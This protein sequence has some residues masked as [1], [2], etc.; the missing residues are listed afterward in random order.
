MFLHL[1]RRPHDH[2]DEFA[3]ADLGDRRRPS[4]APG[5]M[6]ARTGPAAV[7]CPGRRGLHRADLLVPVQLRVT[8]QRAL[9]HGVAHAV[10]DLAHLCLVGP[11]DAELDR[12]T[13]RRAD[14]E[15]LNTRLDVGQG[16]ILVEELHQSGAH[17]FALLDTRRLDDELGEPRVGQIRL[18]RQIEARRPGAGVGGEEFDVRIFRQS[19]LEQLHLALRG[20][21]RRALA[22][23]QI[24]Q[25][26]RPRCG[27]EELLLHRQH[28]G[29]GDGEGQHREGQDP[30]LVLHRPVDDAAQPVVDG[31]VVDV[32]V[33]A[34]RQ[35]LRQQKQ[36]R[37][38]VNLA[39]T[40][41]K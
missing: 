38:G 19:C 6:S 20:G 28:A 7:P 1:G 25:Q 30:R 40:H 35:V 16:L 26:F 21:E 8:Y 3:A 15:A 33:A 36:P 41:D 2:V 24:H 29:A 5:L 12:K 11:D 17:A 39:T 13:H 4:S 34:G 18:D 31:P 14:L 32:V 23:P 9:A 37:Y 22:Q 27:G 10:G